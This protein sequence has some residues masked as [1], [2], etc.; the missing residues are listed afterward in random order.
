M[1]P[2]AAKGVI[3]RMECGGL[4]HIETR[5]LWLQAKY[6]QKEL[7]VHKEPTATN[8]ADGF[9]KAIPFDTW[10]RHMTYLHNDKSSR[11]Q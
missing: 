4:K 7:R 6:D 9:T 5:L 3:T 1:K 8:V 11:D 2:R 10:K